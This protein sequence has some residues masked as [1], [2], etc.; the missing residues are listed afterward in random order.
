M[1]RSPRSDPRSGL[2]RSALLAAC[3]GAGALLVLGL[4][5]MRGDGSRAAERGRDRAPLPAPEAALVDPPATAAPELVP[6]AALADVEPPTAVAPAAPAPAPA[7]AAPVTA[8][9][10]AAGAGDSA[11]PEAPKLHS[12][13]REGKPVKVKPGEVRQSTRRAL[14][15]QRARAA[16]RAAANGETLEPPA[17]P[18]TKLRRPARRPQDGG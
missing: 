16:E 3:A 18:R 12:L 11:E 10:L 2:S 9:A 5:L 7:Q 13:K 8:L 15:D 6:A 1:H 14:K 17:K 4:A